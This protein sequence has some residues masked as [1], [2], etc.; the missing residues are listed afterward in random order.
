MFVR[1]LETRHL[2]RQ[3]KTLPFLVGEVH[4]YHQDLKEFVDIHHA[5]FCNE[6]GSPIVTVQENPVVVRE[7][8]EA[9]TPIAPKLV[10]SIVPETPPEPEIPAAPE[11]LEQLIA[12]KPPFAQE[13]AVQ[14]TDAEEP[15]QRRGR[16]PNTPKV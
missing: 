15:A 16:P 9:E 1:F 6:D 7:E 4:P 12:R 11:P 3:N 10:E 13:V 5:E 14:K 8:I 2:R